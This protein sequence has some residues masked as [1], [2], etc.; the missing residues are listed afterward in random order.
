MPGF[1]AGIEAMH[2]RFGRLHFPDLFAPA[3]WYA[4]RGVI[5]NPPLAGCFNLR[6]QFLA[7]TPEGRHFL[8]QAGNELPRLG[9]RFKQL[10]LAKTLRAVAE[11]GARYMYTGAGLTILSRRSS[12][13]GV[14]SRLTTWVGTASSG[15]HPSRHRSRAIESTRPGSRVIPPITSCRLSIWQKN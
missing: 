9:G 4:E 10:E 7:R 8:N 11:Q 15:A 5:V 6:R 2:A 3:I 14:K 13:K 1:M 12:A